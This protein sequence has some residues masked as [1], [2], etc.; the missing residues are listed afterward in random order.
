MVGILLKT[1][2]LENGGRRIRLSTVGGRFDQANA[3]LLEGT[4]RA[5]VKNG[6]E[7]SLPAG[8]LRLS[9]ADIRDAFRGFRLTSI[10][11]MPD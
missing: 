7:T 1:A 11:S 4:A 3:A 8:G 2:T 6:A 5:C 10:C 9:E